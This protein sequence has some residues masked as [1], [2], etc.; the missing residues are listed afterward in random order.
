MDLVTYLKDIET[1]AQF[2][3]KIK[4]APSLLSQWKTG[5]RPI[6]DDRCPEIEYQS[7]GAMTCEELRFDLCW[8]RVPDPDWPHPEGR[9]LVDHFVR[10]VA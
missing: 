2:A 4:A 10:K 3:V 9:P 6:P 8:Y 1:A 5:R 7:G